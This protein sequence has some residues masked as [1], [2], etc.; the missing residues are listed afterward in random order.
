LTV[1]CRRAKSTTL[2]E[3]RA[4][5]GAIECAARG[6]RYGAVETRALHYYPKK[7]FFCKLKLPLQF[8]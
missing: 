2:R 5:F 7:G 8:L 3:N 6:Q 1:P 4:P